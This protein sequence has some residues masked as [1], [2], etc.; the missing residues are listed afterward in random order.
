MTATPDDVSALASTSPVGSTSTILTRPLDDSATIEIPCAF[1]GTVM[2][3]S[4]VAPPASVVLLDCVAPGA[5]DGCA[6][7]DELSRQ[8]PS[9]YVTPLPRIS[10]VCE[11]GCSPPYRALKPNCGSFIPPVVPA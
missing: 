5:L 11:P 9:T 2:L 3:R 6:L 10:S 7:D 4:A 1:E 8:K